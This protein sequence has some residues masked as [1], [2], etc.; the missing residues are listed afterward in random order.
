M[1]YTRTRSSPIRIRLIRPKSRKQWQSRGEKMRSFLLKGG[2]KVAGNRFIVGALILRP[3]SCHP[4]R[5]EPHF[6]E[7]VDDKTRQRWTFSQSST[8]CVSVI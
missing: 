4:R 7:G 3:D 1:Y 5:R 6:D 2:R 8:R